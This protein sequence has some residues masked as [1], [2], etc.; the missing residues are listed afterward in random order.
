M[1]HGT[2]SEDDKHPQGQAWC[3]RGEPG[4]VRPRTLP[5]ARPFAATWRMLVVFTLCSA[6]SGCITP[7]EK[8]ALMKESIPKIDDV[9]G[10]TERRM[11]NLFWLRR[12]EN[13]SLVDDSGS[14]KPLAGTEDFNAATELY[15]DEEFAQAQ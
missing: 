3:H 6:F 14:L 8:Y 10:P 12:Q 2:A 13:S 11:R 15:Q 7:W 9:Q 5:K 4:A 1:Q